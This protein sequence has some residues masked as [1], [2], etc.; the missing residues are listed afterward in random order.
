MSTSFSSSGPQH[1]QSLGIHLCIIL[2]DLKGLVL[3]FSIPTIFF[4][5]PP[6]LA[7]GSRSRKGK[8]L[9]TEKGPDL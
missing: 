8:K 6:A 5:Y 7:Q 3:V 2:V 4:Y 1:A 9:I